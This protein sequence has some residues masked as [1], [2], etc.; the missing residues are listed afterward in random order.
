MS[1]VVWTGNSPQCIRAHDYN[2]SR[3][4]LPAGSSS[5][6]ALSTRGAQPQTHDFCRQRLRLHA[7]WALSWTWGQSLL[8]DCYRAGEGLWQ[9]QRWAVSGHRKRQHFP[10]EA[11]GNVWIDEVIGHLVK[12]LQIKGALNSL[13]GLS[14]YWN[15]FGTL[16]V[17]TVLIWS[18][19]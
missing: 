14:F 13:L 17:K 19:R 11:E 9:K 10:S 5:H 16:R 15:I 4:S 12:A 8:W 2:N 7:R 1:A 3:F 18:R 6:A